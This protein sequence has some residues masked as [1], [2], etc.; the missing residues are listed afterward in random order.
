[1][2]TELKHRRSSEDGIALI[3]V[4]GVLAFVTI[5]V[6]SGFALSQQAL[7][8]STTAKSESQA[9]QA[10][11]AGLDAAVAYVQYQ[12]FNESLLTN[13]LHYSESELQSGA[14]TVTVELEAG[15]CLKPSFADVVAGVFT[16]AMPFIR[17]LTRAI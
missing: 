10:A 7:M 13:P 3:T 4:I 2:N 16:D 1:M 8:E 5:L 15:A 6:I 12:G 9:F 14:A 17:W 11:N